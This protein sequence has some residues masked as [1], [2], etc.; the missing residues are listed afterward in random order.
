[1]LLSQK[2]ED[3]WNC[4]LESANISIHFA[5]IC[6]HNQ[7]GTRINTMYFTGPVQLTNTTHISNTKHRGLQAIKPEFKKFKY[8][9]TT[10]TFEEIVMG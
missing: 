5:S 4:N 6:A 2:F 10:Y 1:M 7:F 9:D 3:S 8:F